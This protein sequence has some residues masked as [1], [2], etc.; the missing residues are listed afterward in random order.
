[1]TT[2]CS[3][4]ETVQIFCNCNE[5][6]ALDALGYVSEFRDT[7][8]DNVAIAIGLILFDKQN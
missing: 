1:M 7:E 4:F 3:D 6:D 5:Q 8:T 2:L